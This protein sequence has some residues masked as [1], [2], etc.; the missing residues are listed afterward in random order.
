M[1]LHAASGA[2]RIHRQMC[3]NSLVAVMSAREVWTV[4]KNTLSMQDGSLSQEG[5]GTQGRDVN[6]DRHTENKKHI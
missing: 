5:A 6:I 2:L 3:N 4:S 1:P